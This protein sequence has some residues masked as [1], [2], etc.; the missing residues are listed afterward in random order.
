MQ[1]N[2]NN[3]FNPDVLSCLANLSSDEVFTPPS[4]VNEML[5]MLPQEL[6][7]DPN[8][9]F[10]DPACKTG[11]FLRE[12]TK[13]LITGLEP[14]YPDLEE[15]L[16]HIYEWQ[17]FGVAL[18]ELTGL[19]SRR[20][21]Y[22]SKR[23][24]SDYSVLRFD[25]VNGNIMYDSKTK[26]TWANG[27][28]AICGASQEQYDREDVLESYAYD[29]IHRKDLEELLKMQFDV[30]IGN[31]PYQ[32][33]D[34]GG[35]LGS[36]ATPL[37]HLFVQQAKKLNPRYLSMIIP[38][39]WFS[40]GKGLDKFR[41][42][43]LLDRRICK[44][45]DYRDGS[46]CFPGVEITGGICYFLWDRDNPGDCEFISHVG[47]KVSAAV[48]PLVESGLDT[49]IRYN[50]AISIINKV[51]GKNEN[52]FVDHVSTSKPFGFRSNINGKPRFFSK[53]VKL[54]GRGN[55]SYVS[56]KEIIVNP[57]WIDQWKVYIPKAYGGDEIPVVV[58]GKPIVGSPGTCCTE[59][60]LVIGPFTSEEICRNVVSYIN[61][62]FFR[63][64]VMQKKNS[65]NAT[66]KVYFLVPDQDFS[67]PWTDEDL[68]K[69]YGLTE[70]EIAFIESM[71]RPKDNDS[72]K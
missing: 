29:F 46:D 47:G 20:T 25:R 34:G 36:S 35:G 30:I 60:Y 21:L 41:E 18:T 38:S 19:M 39:R 55:I 12:I 32:L 24:N 63:F 15:R 6:F 33:S 26:H 3:P 67:R 66:R 40:G 57:E 14:V 49:L 43:M 51:R 61:T 10:L 52:S 37:Y 44:I 71:V 2:N 70:E 23:A 9:T 59:T 54:Y 4:I 64:L 5:D 72:N 11:V 7:R 53:S 8:T 68:Y 65:Q 56:R 50:E 42:E 28:C 31:P 58:L 69:K 13:R 16:Q 1:T 48:R 62:R 17:V 22:C 45:V 27:S